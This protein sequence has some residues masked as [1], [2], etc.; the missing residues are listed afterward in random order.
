VCP[1]V[2]ACIKKGILP[3]TLTISHAVTISHLPPCDFHLC[4]RAD[5]SLQ[6][7]FFPAKAASRPHLFQP[8]ITDESKIPKLVANHFLLDRAVL[9]WCPAIGGDILTPNTNEIVVFSSFF[10][11]GF[12]LPACNFLRGLLDHYKIELVH[13]NPNS[14][15]Q[16]AI[17]SI[18][19]KH[20]LEFLLIFL[21]SRITFS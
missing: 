6:Q 4:T 9:Q 11:R 16:I 3:S 13:L 10:Q 5:L 14:I 8:S 18:F 12:G 7:N 2:D 21:C 1:L 20:S 17:F 15:L 19:A